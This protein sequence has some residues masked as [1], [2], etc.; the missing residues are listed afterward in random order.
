M[1]GSGNALEAATQRLRRLDQLDVHN[2][3]R[4]LARAYPQVGKES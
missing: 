4:S 1:P 2:P 3:A